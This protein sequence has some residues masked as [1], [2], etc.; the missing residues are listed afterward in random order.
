MILEQLYLGCL[1]HASYFVADEESKVAAV[2]DPRRDVEEYLALAARHGVTIRHVLLT[3]FHADFVAGHLELRD[4]CGARIHLGA[5]ATAEYAFE[6]MKDGSRID[7]GPRVRL[8]TLETPGH[9]PEAISILL[10]DRA[11]DDARPHAVLTG[12]T[13]FLGDVGRPDLLASVGISAADLAG[14]L[15]D[16]LHG[17]LLAL[18]DETLVYPGHGAGSACGKA[19]SDERVSTLGQQR[20]LNYALQP[21]A[22]A[23]FVRLLTSEL[24][25]PPAYF[26]YDA[27]LN[28]KERATLDASMKRALTP[29]PLA[30]VLERAHEGAQV[31]DVRSPT[32]FEGAHL[33]GT[34]NI[35]LGGKYAT[36]AG[37]VLDRTRP[38][39]LIC[40]A[41]TEEEA[42]VRLGRIGFDNV[43]GFLEGGIEALEARPDLV[44]SR[45]R[46]SAPALAEELRAKA[47][48][49]LV[50]VR[51][52]AEFKANRIEGSVNFPL[53]HLVERAGEIPKG[54]PLV[55][56]CRSGYRSAIGAS[57]LARLGIESS[58]LVGG[59]EAWEAAGLPTVKA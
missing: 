58:D 40:G 28:K 52:P 21:M 5:R 9:T 57:L 35:G 2:V 36:W 18:P 13:L 37:S 1:A 27:E 49:V 59:I 55:L 16:S 34:I 46:L 38:I 6:P 3:H 20:R 50:D 45:T 43:I 14:Q 23:D 15:Y 4:R 24:G 33:E 41:G 11:K 10:F 22:R 12:D 32:D 7:L 54:R 8:E 39:V 51:A 17:K 30:T 19:L 44:R 31:V 29:L 47:P 42:A 48:P 26:A 25:E 56:G 53:N